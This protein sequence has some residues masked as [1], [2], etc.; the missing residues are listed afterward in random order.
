MSWQEALDLAWLPQLWHDWSHCSYMLTHTSLTIW[1]RW[2]RAG[3]GGSGFTCRGNTGSAG[4]SRY[5]FTESKVVPQ[6]LDSLSAGTKLRIWPRWEQAGRP[7]LGCAGWGR[8]HFA[9]RGVNGYGGC[10]ETGLTVMAGQGFAGNSRSGFKWP[11][12]CGYASGSGSGFAECWLW[13]ST[14]NSWRTNLH[15][16]YRMVVMVMVVM[17]AMVMVVMIVM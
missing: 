16:K 8:I 3:S 2:E 13:C 4:S 9:G 10:I 7:G 15:V 6:N 14:Y 17:V 1:Q 5:G 11:I 12:G